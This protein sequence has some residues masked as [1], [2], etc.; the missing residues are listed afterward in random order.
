VA[1]KTRQVNL[2][3][4]GTLVD[5]IDGVRGEMPRDRLLRAVAT[6]WFA[7]HRHDSVEVAALYVREAEQGFTLDA[8]VL[9][10]LPDA[11]VVSDTELRVRVFNQGAERLF[12]WAAAE[13]SGQNI[14]DVLP[15]AW[16]RHETAQHLDA[17][18]RGGYWRSKGT[19]FAK[20]GMTV[21]AEVVAQRVD[22]PSGQIRGFVAVFREL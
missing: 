3:M 14:L 17:V 21:R 7:F 1:P 15:S 2:R 12:R 9:R 6:R 22:D 10:I 19:W 20:D 5:A 4:P 11:V 13:A 16:T 8:G 18:W